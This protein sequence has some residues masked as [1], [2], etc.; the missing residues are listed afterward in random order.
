M[1]THVVGTLENHDHSVMWLFGPILAPMRLLGARSLSIRHGESKQ[2][3]SWRGPD[4]QGKR[5]AALEAMSRD[6]GPPEEDSEEDS[7]RS[8][9]VGPLEDPP[10]ANE[11]GL[12]SG[13]FDIGSDLSIAESLDMA[14]SYARW[15]SEAE[16]GDPHVDRSAN[17]DC[18]VDPDGLESAADPTRRISWTPR[19]DGSDN[20]GLRAVP[21][22]SELQPLSGGSSSEASL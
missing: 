14:S 8:S 10:L 2:S 22:R 17:S 3:A 11:L 5:H 6:S 9:E 18:G 15:P 12:I 21:D 16:Q 4:I 19:F 20:S 1:S 7:R 13:S